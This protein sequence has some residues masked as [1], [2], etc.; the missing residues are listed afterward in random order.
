MKQLFTLLFVVLVSQFTFGQTCGHTDYTWTSQT[1]IDNFV[2]TY[3]GGGC[4]QIDGDLY[5]TGASINDLSGLTF[6]TEITGYLYI[7]STN[8]TDLTGLENLTTLG[9]FLYLQSNNSLLN[10]DGLQNLTSFNSNIQLRY[11]NNLTSIV[12]LSGIT[13][14]T[15]ISLEYNPNIATLNGLHN[16]ASPDVQ[17]SITGSD[18]LVDLTG[19]DA[20]TSASS[21][22]IYTNDN[23]ASLDGLDN[24]TTTANL[25]IDRNFALANVDALS[26]LTQVDGSFYFHDAPTLTDISFITC[27]VEGI[28]FSNLG[29][30]DLGGIS[31]SNNE[32]DFLYI[33]FVPSLTDISALNGLE[34]VNGDL[35]IWSTL[36]ASLA[37]FEDLTSISGDATISNNS[38]LTDV[39][40]FD[41]VLYLGEDLV[42]GSNS[43]LSECCV[44]Q[45]FISGNGFIGGSINIV[46]NDTNCISIPEVITY[47]NTTY[48]DSDGDGVPDSTDNCASESNPNQEDTDGDGIGNPCDNC[49]DTANASQTD[50]DGDGIGDDCETAA[51]TT[52]SGVGGVGINTT[53]PNTLLEVADGDIFINN[54]HRGVIM[55]SASGNCFRYQPDDSGKL[56]SKQI[57]CPDN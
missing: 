29:I 50:T 44:F 56:V 57:T 51:G 26:N 45:N 53:T 7:R 54:I 37:G 38:V 35:E 19:L 2:T 9:T 39:S 36:L 46:G 10:I 31:A 32:L 4:S 52:G 6:I 8:L 12:G 25:Y 49:P 27:T 13:Q 47:C 33:N 24:L 21:I 43:S 20:I 3:G 5:I 18:A 34:T 55:K 30:T 1:E 23:L 11:N 14:A 15:A 40:Q 48:A 22:S 17:I 16:I 42:V 28:N 41:N